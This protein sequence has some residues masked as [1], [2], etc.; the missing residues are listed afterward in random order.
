MLVHITPNIC[1][2]AGVA[3]SL[4]DYLHSLNKVR[5][6]PVRL[7]LSAHRAET[8]EPRKRVDELAAYHARRIENAWET[9][10]LTAYD[11]AG[12]MARSI[13][14]RNWAEF[15]PTQKF[16]AVD[17]DPIKSFKGDYCDGIERD[18]EQV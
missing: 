6:L 1:R 16:F 5:G 10:G 11:I 2:W 13:H 15:P 12:R 3:D 4:G 18:F 17:G 14:C 7:L 9:P 8:G